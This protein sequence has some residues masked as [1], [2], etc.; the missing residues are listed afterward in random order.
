MADINIGRALSGLG[1][2]FKNEMPAF[3]QQVRQEDA[4][5]RGMEDRVLAQEEKRKETLFKDTATARQYLQSGNIPAIIDIYSDRV[6]LLGRAG[7]DTSNSERMLS[8]A[9]AALSDPNALS[10]L[11]GEINTV[12]DTGRAFNV[13]M[14][15]MPSSYRALRQRA[16]DGGLIEGSKEF[17]DF[18]RLNGQT[19]GEGSK[20]LTRFENGSYINITPQGPRVYDITGSEVTNPADMA[21]V[22][23]LGRDSGV[24][25]ASD[26]AQAT[27]RSKA[28]EKR[29]QDVL[30]NGIRA[31]K[32]IG[33][34]KS[35]MDIL[36]RGL[37]TGGFAS[38][39]LKVKRA[40][41]LTNAD[42]ALFA[43]TLRKNVLQQLKP[44]FGAAFT[45]REGEMLAEIEA[46]EN[47]S[48]E[49][50]MALIM[51]L[52]SFMEMD[53]DRARSRARTMGDSGTYAIEDMD[54]FLSKNF[55]PASN[56]QPASDETI[57]IIVEGEEGDAVYAALLSGAKYR[58]ET[59]SSSSTR[60]KP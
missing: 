15:E 47:Q 22:L 6:N 19:Q 25:L 16:L 51:D 28:E 14:G 8:Y 1:A 46:N 41:G 45:A 42:E 54:G 37:E 40:L 31:S 50:N 20:G 5:A 12:Y 56:D 33:K 26:L 32:N 53:I 2:A 29:Y 11:T 49:A 10:Q 58:F 17:Q 52:I 3:M 55:Y 24:L 39:S 35:A 18:M 60:T 38:L 59:D 30:D 23:R 7:I 27:A 21:E 34:L 43:Y 4:L 13:G 9:Q 57:T 44:T 36:E 48:T